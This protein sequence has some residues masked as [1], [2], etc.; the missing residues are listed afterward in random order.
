MCTIGNL[1]VS[2]NVMSG[3]QPIHRTSTPPSSPPRSQ[4]WA[5][6][7]VEHLE[8]KELWDECGINPDI[9]VSKCAHANIRAGLTLV[10]SHSRTTFRVRTSTSLYHVT[11]CTKL[12][13]VHSR[14]ISLR[15]SVITWRVSTESQRLQKSWLI[16]TAS[17]YYK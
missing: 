11:S 4:V 2:P 15:G 13:R 14:T 12:S 9:I 6:H 5:E 3:I 17:A 10:L 8:K 16:L 7:M 1:F